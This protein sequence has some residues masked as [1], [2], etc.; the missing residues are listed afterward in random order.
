MILI[1]RQGETG[2]QVSQF[3]IDPCR[4]IPLPA[5]ALKQL[6]VVPLTSPND[7]SIEVHLTIGIGLEYPLDDLIL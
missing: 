4:D 2:L 1:P 5:I 3:A 6:S 7:R